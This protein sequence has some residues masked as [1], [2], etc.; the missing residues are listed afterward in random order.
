MSTSLTATGIPTHLQRPA[1]GDIPSQAGLPARVLVFLVS[2]MAAPSFPGLDDPAVSRPLHEVVHLGLT[3]TLE[4]ALTPSYV[5]NI[6]TFSALIKTRIYELCN[7]IL[8]VIV[9]PWAESQTVPAT[10]THE[11]LARKADAVFK[12]R[13]KF[14]FRNLLPTLR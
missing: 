11:T 14:I 13:I 8:H 1:V 2:G 5:T 10:G 4:L 3:A 6:L 7:V 9:I 12:V